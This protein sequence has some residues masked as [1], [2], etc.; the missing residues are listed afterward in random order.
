MNLEKWAI[1][2]DGATPDGVDCH[3]VAPDKG[4]GNAIEI[5]TGI[6][7]YGLVRRL[8]PK[9]IV[10]TGTHWGWSTACIALALEDQAM[11]YSHQA[12]MIETVDHID[13]PQND[14]LW[15]RL[16]IESYIKKYVEDSLT[17]HPSD[18]INLLFLDADHGEEFIITEWI[19]LTQYL[20]SIQ[21]FVL[22]HDTR[23]DVRE[24]KAIQKIVDQQIGPFQRYKHWTHIALRNYR[25]LDMFSFSNTTVI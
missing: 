20:S 2:L 14:I 1:L 24:T 17:F 23:L 19:N 4:N 3:S 7:L 22:L 18:N 16:G 25:G 10:E 11:D 12:G 13:Y 8:N 15:R 6:F 5:E 9:M 21:A